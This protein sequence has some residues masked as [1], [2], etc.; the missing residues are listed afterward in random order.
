MKLPFWNL[1]R[2]D[3]IYPPEFHLVQRFR[4]AIQH[5][6]YEFF[7]NLG[8][9]T[10]LQSMPFLICLV[11]WARFYRVFNILCGFRFDLIRLSQIFGFFNV[12]IF[13]QS[14]QRLLLNLFINFGCFDKILAW[15]N[16]QILIGSLGRETTQPSSSKLI[17]GPLHFH[18]DA[19]GSKEV[20]MGVHSFF[21]KKWDH[22][23]IKHLLPI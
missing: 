16:V 6:Q 13:Y 7:W 21:A 3:S 15:Y 5:V 18:I 12:L 20:K 23:N 11:F 10:N 2:V 14:N 1:L 22:K 19:V 9:A 8:V 17:E 4:L